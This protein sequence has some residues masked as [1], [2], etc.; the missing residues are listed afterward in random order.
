MRHDFLR[1]TRAWI[2]EVST[3]AQGTTVQRGLRNES[4][5][6]WQ[7]ENGAGDERDT[8]D[9]EIPVVRWRLLQIEFRGLRQ[10]GCGE[11]EINNCQNSTDMLMHAILSLSLTASTTP[12]KH[13]SSVGTYN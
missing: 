12:K 11:Q 2:R 6:G 9:K 10:N 3:G 5:T 13:P 4:V 1:H 8:E 7:S